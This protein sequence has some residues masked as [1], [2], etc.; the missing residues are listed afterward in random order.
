MTR[1]SVI[2]GFIAALLTLCQWFTFVCVRRYLFQRSAKMRRRWAYPMLI[3]FGLLAV[4]AIR[5][6]FGAEVFPPGTW[7]RQGA[8]VIL[9]S[10]VGCILVATLFLLILRVIAILISCTGD[11]IQLTITGLGRGRWSESAHGCLPV[12]LSQ[13]ET[14]RYLEARVDPEE[15]RS[16]TKSAVPISCRHATR[17]EFLR[18]AA[19]S[20]LAAT[21]GVGIHGLA[22]AYSPPVVETYDFFDHHLDHLAKPIVLIHVTD[23]HFG[24]FFGIHELRRLVDRLNSLEGDALCVTGD[25]FHSG[26]TV[27]EQATPFLAKLRPRLLGNFAVLGNH[28]FY[29]REARSVPSLKAAGFTL[30]RNQWIT[31]SRGNC[32]IHVGGVDDPMAVRTRAKESRE[33]ATFMRKTPLESGL[34]VV[35]SHRPDLFRRAAKN[36]VDLVLAGHLH[37]GQIVIPVPDRERGISV[38]N[39]VSEYTCGWYKLAKSAMYLNR[40][41]GLSF[42]P[43]RVWCPSE[44]AVIR[45]KPAGDWTRSGSFRKV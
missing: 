6:E 45:L 35:L 28:D 40:G 39:A 2:L 5:I 32:T 7:A 20:G 4:T 10:Y 31:F 29:A 44:I 38:A 25:V 21:A 14:E 19:S 26:H 22:A 13:P 8:S 23:V 41:V 36:K 9:R 12:S 15:S 24:M 43:W 34:R 33:L 1:M 3:A 11:L 17:R 27:I 18:M 42:L 16:G 37:G 30:L